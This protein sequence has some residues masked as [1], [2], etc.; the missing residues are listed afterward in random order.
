M[1]SSV[2]GLFWRGRWC[3]VGL[4]GSLPSTTFPGT[5]GHAQ[6][7]KLLKNLATSN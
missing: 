5:S 3:N 2:M 7:D 4:F 6:N 1:D